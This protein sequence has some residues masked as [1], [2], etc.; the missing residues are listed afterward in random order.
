M[1]K[2]YQKPELIVYENLHDLTG[3]KVDI[4]EIEGS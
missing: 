4:S 2:D 3:D 1:R